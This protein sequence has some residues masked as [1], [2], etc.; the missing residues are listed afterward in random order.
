M[1]VSIGVAMIWPRHEGLGAERLVRMADAALYR[2]KLGGR[3]RVCLEGVEPE[4]VA[5]PQV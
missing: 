2:A 4:T 3:D 5:L 1:T